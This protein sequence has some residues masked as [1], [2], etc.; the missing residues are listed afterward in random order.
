MKNQILDYYKNSENLWNIANKE[1]KD[2]IRYIFHSAWMGA[3]FVSIVNQLPTKLIL[4]GLKYDYFSEEEAIL[5][6]KKKSDK[7][8][9]FS[10]LREVITYLS[11][12]N[13]S[14]RLL[15]YLEL[16]D[17]ENN[18]EKQGAILAICKAVSKLDNDLSRVKSIC[19]A[20]YGYSYSAYEI[21]VNSFQ[22]LSDNKQN[23]TISLILNEINKTND[24]NQT[25]HELLLKI[26]FDHAKTEYVRKEVFKQIKKL[27]KENKISVEWE[28]H[29]FRDRFNPKP[30]EKAEKTIKKI[31]QNKD[32]EFDDELEQALIFLLDT[33]HFEM[34]QEFIPK[35]TNDDVKIRIILNLVR[36]ASKQQKTINYYEF[37]IRNLPKIES[38]FKRL[39]NKGKLLAYTKESPQ[40]VAE[41][42]VFQNEFIEYYLSVN[43]SGEEFRMPELGEIWVN[44]DGTNEFKL[45]EISYFSIMLSE[46]DLLKEALLVTKL[47]DEGKYCFQSKTLNRICNILIDNGMVL[48]TLDITTQ[49]TDEKWIDITKNDIAKGFL[50][51]GKLIEAKTIIDEINHSEVKAIAYENLAI[52]LFNTGKYDQSINQISRI[53]EKSNQ[54]DAILT[55]IDLMD[56]TTHNLEILNTILSLCV[57]LPD[58]KEIEKVINA[59]DKEIISEQDKKEIQERYLLFKQG[60]TWFFGGSENTLPREYIGKEREEKLNALYKAYLEKDREDYYPKQPDIELINIS[61]GLFVNDMITEG[62]Q[63][64]QKIQNK[65]NYINVLDSVPALLLPNNVDISLKYIHILM[66][67]LR[68]EERAYIISFL[69]GD[70]LMSNIGLF[71][72][73]GGK[74]LLILMKEIIKDN[75]IL[76]HTED[77]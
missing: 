52:Y 33:N 23:N 54:L 42:E 37:A 27:I 6:T 3:T 70:V 32:P 72:Y 34:V 9:R 69:Q 16:F 60:Q 76:E 59:I 31:L 66:S 26:L 20:N 47:I 50:T 61:R 62:E 29:N 1:A 2:T 7:N 64:V 24:L 46:L 48:D 11:D 75:A 65:Q 51:Q 77:M 44:D 39:L 63:L 4:S 21:I 28:P 74:E 17:D 49:I 58:K 53:P 55:I 19:F 38:E 56:E 57:V 71:N 35:I 12:N 18:Y 15:N 73:F 10:C 36:A 68:N 40:Y 30:S 45:P 5:F 43:K 67:I 8:K 22:F 14:D 41:R 25:T 13:Y